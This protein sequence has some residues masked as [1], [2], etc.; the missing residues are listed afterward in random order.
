M[1]INSLHPE[2][3][4]F[5]LGRSTLQ[6][7]LPS[8]RA[9]DGDPNSSSSRD[10]GVVFPDARGTLLDGG[11]DNQGGF[12]QFEKPEQW[13]WDDGCEDEDIREP[14][15]ERIGASSSTVSKNNTMGIGTSKDSK[16]R[17]GTFESVNDR[18]KKSDKGLEIVKKAQESLDNLISRTEGGITTDTK[19]QVE[20]S[21]PGPAYK[22]GPYKKDKKGPKQ[23]GVK[24]YTRGP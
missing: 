23:P 15:I 8:F 12:K 22:R 21:K 3:K 24:M 9:G 13:K 11:G 18:S 16:K 1:D 2:N 6:A 14:D 7:A 10:L 17:I 19:V 4:T 20:V 5:A